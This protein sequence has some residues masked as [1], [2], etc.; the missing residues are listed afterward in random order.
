[1]S[2]GKLPTTLDEVRSSHSTWSVCANVSVIAQ[3]S[4]P[5]IS[6]GRPH[7]SYTFRFKQRG[8]LLRQTL[9]K[10]PKACQPRV[11]IRPISGFQSLSIEMS[12]YI[13]ILSFQH[14]DNQITS[15]LREDTMSNDTYTLHHSF[16]PTPPPSQIAKYWKHYTDST[17][18]VISSAG[19]KTLRDCL[20]DSYCDVTLESKFHRSHPPLQ[21]TF[22]RNIGHVL[23][24][25]DL[26]NMSNEVMVPVMLNAEIACT[27][28]CE[29][30]G[31][32]NK[33][34]EGVDVCDCLQGF[35]GTSCET[36]IDDCDPNPCANLA[37]CVDSVNNYT[38]NCTNGFT[39]INCEIPADKCAPN[40]CENNGIC[41]TTQDLSFSCSCPAGW[42]GSVCDVVQDVCASNPCVHGSCSNDYNEQATYSCQCDSGYVGEN[43]E[44]NFDDCVGIQC[45][46]G[47]VCFDLVNIYECRC[48]NGF[49]GVNCAD[50]IVECFENSC[51]NGGTCSSDSKNITCTCPSGW[52]G[53]FCEQDINECDQRPCIHGICQNSEGS[54]QCYCTPGYSGANCTIDVNECLSRPCK[55]GATC[56][57]DVNQYYCACAPGYKGR[58]CEIDINEC[59]S[60]PC[61]NGATCIDLVNAYNCSCVPGFM[62]NECEINIDECESTPCQNNGQCTDLINEFECNCTDT[63]FFGL[64]CENNID[65]CEGQPCVSDG[66]CTDLIKDYQCNCHTGYG[67]KNCEEDINE[68][69]TTPCQNDALCL[70]KSNRTLYEINYKGMFSDPFTYATSGGYICECVL[71]FNGTDC[72][73]NIDDCVN[74]LCVNGTCVDGINNYSCECIPGFEGAYCDLEIDEC[75][76]YSPCENEGTCIDLIGDYECQCVG[77]FGGKNCSDEL[78]GCVDNQCANEAKCHPYIESGEHKYTCECRNGFY[79]K[80]CEISSSLSFHGNGYITSL[81]TSSSSQSNLFAIEFRFRTTIPNGVLAV[82]SSYDNNHYFI[83]ALKSGLVSVNVTSNDLTTFFTLG[84]DIITGKE[85]V[86]VNLNI[87]TQ[88]IDLRV[89]NERKIENF[90]FQS[91]ASLSNVIVGGY[92]FSH[93]LYTGVDPFIGCMQD[94]I[95]NKEQRITFMHS[96]TKFE[97]KQDCDRIDQCEPNP[98]KNDGTCFDLWNDFSCQCFRPY[99]GLTCIDYVDPAT[100]GFE[101][102]E[103]FAKLLV[104]P[105]LQPELQRN[106][107]ISLFI[108][109]RKENGVIFYLGPE[110]INS[111]PMNNFLLVQLYH[112]H[113]EA[114]VNNKKINLF[115]QTPRLDDGYYHRIETTLI[116]G[117]LTA[118]ANNTIT[119]YQELYGGAT[120]DPQVLYM[121]NIPTDNQ[122]NSRQKRQVPGNDAISDGFKGV[123]WDMLIN[124]R[125]VPFYSNSTTQQPAMGTTDLNGV[126]YGV[127]SDN[128]CEPNPCENNGHCNVTWNDYSCDC[129]L[130]FRG[131]NCSDHKPCSIFKCPGNAQCVDLKDGYECLTTVTL[132]GKDSSVSYTANVNGSTFNDKISFR[133]RT[134]STGRVILDINSS[135]GSLVIEVNSQITLLWN[136]GNKFEFGFDATDGKWHN[137]SLSFKSTNVICEF[138]G[139]HFNH[140]STLNLHEMVASPDAAIIVGSITPNTDPKL[141]GL[142]SENHHFKGCIE[143]IRISDILLPF[144]DRSQMPNDTSTEYFAPAF[145]STSNVMVDECQVCFES[146]CLNNGYCENTT[147]SFNCQCS[148]GF[149]GQFCRTNIDECVTNKCMNNATCIDGIGDYSCNCTDGFIGKFCETDLCSPEPC[150]HGTCSREPGTYSCDCDW[151][152]AGVNC[153]EPKTCSDSPS[154]CVHGSCVPKAG[155]PLFDCSCYKGY[156]GRSCDEEK[157]YCDPEP[158]MHGG[159]CLSSLKNFNYTCECQPGWTGPKCSV[160]IND[161]Y[162]GLCKNGGK[163][164]DLINN[165]TCQCPEAFTGRNCELD[166]N[167]CKEHSGLCQ[168]GGNCNNIWG[169]FNCSCS[170]GFVGKVCNVTDLC[171]ET[172]IC[173]NDGLCF[174]NLYTGASYCTCTDSYTGEFCAKAKT[175]ETENLA[176]VIGPVVGIFILICVMASLLTFFMMARKKRATRGTYSPSRQEMFGSRVEMGNFACFRKTPKIIEQNVCR[177]TY[178]HNLKSVK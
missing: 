4:D 17:S 53:E 11:I 175:E 38:C 166:A 110:L 160:N 122:F 172:A 178:C 107:N 94:I 109:T 148:V 139:Q 100:F 49:G 14:Y 6:T 126:V 101:D 132:N 97:V 169:S 30:G 171:F 67:G 8:S 114:I 45:D 58:N 75:E 86:T 31:E 167:E 57:N 2:D 5:Y 69:L 37:Q 84:K 15:F 161:C 68:C 130:A 168:N 39:G 136:N 112:G 64:M 92:G 46:S 176:L 83:L 156:V 123:L 85:Y 16:I 127:V 105:Q 149:I 23:H 162:Q 47:K 87:E 1:M 121:G 153:T 28:S 177:K 104:S 155:F 76:R 152:Y 7:W 88:G 71:G 111:Q 34:E 106:L 19:E 138:D 54:F 10:R 147:E 129:P 73:N 163:C 12:Y 103:S 26:V 32:C 108:R 51:Q 27:A 22:R 81:P 66:N 134:N 59:E 91:P 18:Y 133:Y 96:D 150:L 95:V 70:E 41:S 35:S 98:C 151:E 174:M 65:D 117:S 24:A 89:G 62:G 143:E 52:T 21:N 82:G 55:N 9:F 141:L 144:F 99:F 120:L 63:G 80:F 44:T 170:V 142:V 157:D 20:L 78:I 33:N 36:D 135:E 13:C 50:R 140:S 128:T 164:E 74:N 90:F 137:V 158:C 146:D 40:P 79:E 119:L 77:L 102:A 56:Q 48:P 165:Y 145:M 3:V 125:S 116:N 43:C 124:G 131:K 173:F 118:T 93:E 159:K 61:Q 154:P 29:N 42:T 115:H 113:L 60:S 72:E 25:Y